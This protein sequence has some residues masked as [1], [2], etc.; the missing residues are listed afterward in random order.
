MP[1]TQY[2]QSFHTIS[3]QG[4]YKNAMLKPRILNWTRENR[5]FRNKF[6]DLQESA[7]SPSG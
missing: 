6:N 3:M 7:I 4:F 1:V 5:D 2:L